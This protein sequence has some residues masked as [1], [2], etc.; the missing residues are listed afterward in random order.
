M[1][2]R[3]DLSGCTDG[4]LGTTARY[5]REPRAAKVETVLVFAEEER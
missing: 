3:K 4:S 2:G 1:I 5:G